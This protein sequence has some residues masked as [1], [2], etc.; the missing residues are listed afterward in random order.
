MIPTQDA[1]DPELVEALARAAGLQ[2]ALEQFREDVFAAVQ[3]VETQRR[4]LTDAP[5]PADEPWP[6]MQVESIDE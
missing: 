3:V 2:I 1:I 6:P 5:A 4:A